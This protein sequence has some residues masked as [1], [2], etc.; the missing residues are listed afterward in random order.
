MRLHWIGLLLGFLLLCV[1]AFGAILSL[2]GSLT[3]ETLSETLP[4]AFAPG[5]WEAEDF[6]VEW[7]KGPVAGIEAVLEPESLQWVRVA[8]VLALPRAR[9]ILRKSAGGPPITGRVTSGGFSQDFAGGEELAKIPVSL[10]E[11]DD[12]KITVTAGESKRDLRVV[13][14]PRVFD[15]PATNVG[16]DASCSRYGVKAE[17][18]NPALPSLIEIGCRFV[19]T[20]GAAH[21]TS[22]LEILVSW[23]GAHQIVAPAILPGLWAFRER[24]SQEPLVIA[25]GAEKLS[26]SYSIP[27]NFHYGSLGG[28]LGPYIFDF[29]DPGSQYRVA[30]P[31]LTLYGSY[32][33]TEGSRLVAFG[34]ATF[35]EH[36]TADFGVHLNTESLRTLDR[37]L[38]I[39]VMLGAHIIG[40]KFGGSY[41]VHPGAPQGVEVIYSDAF[42]RGKNLSLGGFVYPEIDGKAYYNLW[43]RWGSSTFLELNYIAW[44]DLV[45]QAQIFCRDVGISLGM[46]LARFF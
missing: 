8:D 18:Q 38:A 20:E 9:L 19:E 44:K 31:T 17:L 35:N 22:T 29:N 41:V 5:P 26:I 28:G 15:H 2:P 13:F 7:V 16:I 6:Q 40:Y 46:P 1:N 21:R 3:Q 27:G 4:T 24:P 42:A 25:N 33:L 23:N 39:N 12:N 34:L 32:F 37:R 14:R 45:G 10:L 36:M 11:A 30:T 43:I